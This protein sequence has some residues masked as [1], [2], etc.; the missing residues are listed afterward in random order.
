MAVRAAQRVGASNTAKWFADRTRIA[1]SPVKA[2]NCLVT[3]LA[4]E[5]DCSRGVSLFI[6][7][8]S[9]KT[10]VS[11]LKQCA[12]VAGFP[13]VNLSPP[14]R[15]VRNKRRS[16]A[17]PRASATAL[18][19]S[20]DEATHNNLQQEHYDRDYAAY[21]QEVPPKVTESLEKIVNAASL[22][23]SHKVLDCGCGPGRLIPH[24]LA[25]GVEDVVAVDLSIMMIALVKE[26]FDN[27]R[28][29]QGDIVNL[30][31]AFG[32]FDAIFVNEVLESVHSQEAVLK[33]VA[34]LLQPGGA[35]IISHSQ[36]RRVS[37]FYKKKSPELHPHS[38]PDTEELKKL[39]EGASLD[40]EA[41]TDA[42]DFY[43]AVLR[44]SRAS[45]ETP[46][47]REEAATSD[48]EDDPYYFAKAPL[49]MK[50]PVVS[51]FGR[52]SRQLGFP[53]ANL[54]P[55]LLV[56]ELDGLMNGV[57]FGWARLVAEGKDDKVYKMVMNVGNRPT[58]ADGAGQ[59]I[60]VHVLNK[61][62]A[63]FY[64]DELR[65]V[66]LGC[67]RPEQKFSSVA[68]LVNRIKE[69]VAITEEALEDDSKRQFSR[70]TFLLG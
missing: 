45:S 60:E 28:C 42:E 66:V 64:G 57:Y 51:G 67:I 26:Q 47:R 41:F 13:I 53:T 65:V 39:A 22:K 14:L 29:W 38:L 55:E 17:I 35:I 10:T 36:G 44:D 4:V 5:T 46:R 27:V 18:T 62:E 8:L 33:A 54:A 34:G 19:S 25:A 43:L 68:D 56:K 59:T 58:F 31:P 6:S 50:T 37:E 32:P 52:G 61:Y 49:Y 20:N 7:A 63:D 2:G 24:I 30:P 48:W 69:D 3:A 16:S 23:P 21:I 9:R 70:D 1:A 40:V 12:S 11:N 15:G